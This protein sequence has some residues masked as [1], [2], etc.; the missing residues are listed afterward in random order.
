MRANSDYILKIDFETMREIQDFERGNDPP[1]LTRPTGFPEKMEKGTYQMILTQNHHCQYGH[2]RKINA[3]R[4]KIVINTGNMTHQT[5][6]RAT[7][8]IRPTIV[9]TDA[10]YVTGKATGR[11]I[12]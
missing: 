7:I 10:N 6:H 4:R 1:P 8:I 11:G 5:H 12:R 9:I 3:I 2:R